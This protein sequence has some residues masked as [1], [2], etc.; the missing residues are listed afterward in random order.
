[1]HFRVTLPWGHR[2]NFDHDAGDADGITLGI[3]SS[4]ELA[5]ETMARWFRAANA[6]VGI[7]PEDGMADMIA[8]A[9]IDELPYVPEGMQLDVA[10]P[11]DGIWPIM[12]PFEFGVPIDQPFGYYPGDEF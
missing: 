2:F 5:R 8:H 10:C 11:S 9:R 12:G 7:D 3:F 6:F 4:E 1:M